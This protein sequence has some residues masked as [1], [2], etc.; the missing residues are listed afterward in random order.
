MKNR[1]RR[2]I[3][4]V[5]V[6]AVA[7]VALVW[8]LAGAQNTGG[9]DAAGDGGLPNPACPDAGLFGAGLTSNVCWSCL[10][11]IRIG[12]AGGGEGVPPGAS[13]QSAC[14]CDDPLGV[15]EPGIVNGFWQ[16]A[17]LIELVR[18]PYCSPALGGV[19]L[20]RSA[21]LMGGYRSQEQD[22]SDATFYNYHYYAFPLLIILD[23]FLEPECNADGYSDFDLLYLSELDPTWNNDTLAFFVNPEAALFAN[24]VAQAA[25]LADAVSATAGRPLDSL[26]WCAGTW[27]SIYPLS[28]HINHEASPPRDTSLLATRAVAALHRRG[29]AWRTMGDEALCRGY[30]H[31][32]I[33]KT[34]YKLSQFY[35]LPE[36]NGSHPVGQSSFLWGEWRNIPGV[37]EDF[38]HLLYRWVD[39]CL[40]F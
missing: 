3:A 15:P 12:G 29:L 39:C 26:F 33:P 35:P 11:P 27:G 31:P 14:I 40:R 17:R 30:I 32:V 10:L 2:Q 24:P 36:A 22:T 18:L 9:G 5:V 20:R 28:G 6:V 4:G 23:L 16:P 38:V 34:Q 8:P 7:T 13:D 25:C 37:G 19:L 21:R 1:F